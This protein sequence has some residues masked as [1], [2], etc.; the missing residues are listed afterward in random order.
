[1]DKFTSKQNQPSKTDKHKQQTTDKQSN[2]LT[3]KQS[4][5]KLSDKKQQS[6]D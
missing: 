1:M 5:S 4:K 3:D 2:K 6:C